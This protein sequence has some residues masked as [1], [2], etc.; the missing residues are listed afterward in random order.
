VGHDID[1]GVCFR[2]G[3]ICFVEIIG[4]EGFFPFGEEAFVVDGADAIDLTEAFAGLDAAGVVVGGIE[5]HEVTGHLA[6]Y[7]IGE[8]DLLFHECRHSVFAVGG[9]AMEIGCSPGAV[10]ADEDLADEVGTVGF[11]ITAIG[12]RPVLGYVPVSAGAAVAGD[13]KALG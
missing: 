3:E 10:F 6:F 13:D 4:I 11:G 5:P 9:I 7:A 8:A 1:H 12:S 2:V